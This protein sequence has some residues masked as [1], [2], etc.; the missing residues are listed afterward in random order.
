MALENPHQNRRLIMNAIIQLEK[1]GY[2]AVPH[3]GHCTTQAIVK[4][5]KDNNL[6]CANAIWQNDGDKL[7]SYPELNNLV[8]KLLG[9][10][11]HLKHNCKHFFC[12]R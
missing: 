8:V 12:K 4:A 3:T 10:R 1:A 6:A 7:Q 11:T 9:C 5:L 2:K